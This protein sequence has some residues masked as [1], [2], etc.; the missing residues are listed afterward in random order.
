TQPAKPQHSVMR[1]EVTTA[2]V[3]FLVITVLGI[4]GRLIWWGMTRAGSKPPEQHAAANK[5]PHKS[6]P[7]NPPPATPTANKKP[8]E[9]SAPVDPID[10]ALVALKEDD[11]RRRKD[12]AYQFVRMKPVEE[13]R[14]EISA[15]LE[16]VLSDSDAATVEAGV[17]ALAVW[18]TAENV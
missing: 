14:R 2:I 13:R 17:K 10:K 6:P 3:V 8:P 15:A 9:R 1:R 18:G 4:A 7:E 16:T 12:A 11:S 5:P